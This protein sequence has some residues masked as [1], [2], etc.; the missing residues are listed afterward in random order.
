MSGDRLGD[1]VKAGHAAQAA[2]DKLAPRRIERELA[3]ACVDAAAIGTRVG[4]LR[5]LLD[6]AAAHRESRRHANAASLEQAARHELWLLAGLL[7]THF[8]RFT[9][10]ASRYEC[11]CG[12]RLEGAELAA[13]LEV[14][15]T[16]TPTSIRCPKCDGR[17]VR[18]TR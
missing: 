1:F 15:G 10:S 3:Q 14:C 4:R 7:Q 11:T 17:A 18:T 9:A 8:A 6:E 16:S 12:Y 2:V 5:Q 13:F